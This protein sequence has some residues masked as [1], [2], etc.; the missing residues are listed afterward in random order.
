M[1]QL[2][3]YS[4][5]FLF[6]VFCV[7]Q[8]AKF[9]VLPYLDVITSIKDGQIEVGPELNWQ[10]TE[11]GK[12]F[13]IRPLMKM[14]LTSKSENIL[15]ID[16]FT[17]DWSGVLYFQYSFYNSNWD[18]KWVSHS[19]GA[20]FE[21]GANQYKYYP[22]GTKKSETKTIK[23]SFA[24]EVKYFGLW[25]KKALKKY[26]MQF[27][28]QFRLKYIHSWEAGKEM[29]V[30]NP[31]N[32]AGIV[33]LSNMI[34][35]APTVTPTFSPAFSL[36]IYPGRGNFSYA[37]A[38]YYN[39]ISEQGKNNPFNNL[40]RV[41]LECWMFFYPLI[42]NNPNVKIGISPFVSIRTAGT[43]S[44]NPVE[45]GGMITVKFGTSFLQFF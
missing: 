20:Q 11:F 37:P 27:S 3:I 10:K 23:N 6:P 15:K 35:D 7:A 44:F 25:L 26:T 38:V 4:L 39:F 43:D 17:T 40:Q 28:P 16:R 31:P 32:N 21:Y 13:L 24:F 2:Y 33:T 9:K 18:S 19:F 41:R 14:P 29:G 45:Y 34:L 22:M 12:A 30:V 8:N 1:R 42:D 5:L 36:Q